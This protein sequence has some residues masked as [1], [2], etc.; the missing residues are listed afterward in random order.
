MEAFKDYYKFPLKQ[1]PVLEE[2]VL[3]ADDNFAIEFVEED[4]KKGLYLSDVT[5]K[6]IIHA[7]NK[8]NK[9]QQYFPNLN[10][11]GSY[12]KSGNK[13]LISIR[14]WGNLTGIGG[15]NLDVDKAKSIQHQFALYIVNCLTKSL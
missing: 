4:D 1:E 6:E 11:E 5:K 9:I 14:G 2:V 15:H 8:G 10:I 7:L 3:T 13:T 12:I